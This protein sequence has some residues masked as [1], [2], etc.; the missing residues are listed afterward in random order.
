MEKW[1][2]PQ[3]QAM[4]SYFIPAEGKVMQ[5]DRNFSYDE[6]HAQTWVS[7][8]YC[9][10]Q[11]RPGVAQPKAPAHLRFIG[12]PAFIRG[13]SAAFRHCQLETAIFL[14]EDNTVQ[15]KQPMAGVPALSVLIPSLKLQFSIQDFD[16]VVKI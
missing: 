9:G 3:N 8:L 7:Y 16:T 2:F 11:K 5:P 13:A 6:H 15:M 10:E 14:Q 1:S 12:L 4:S